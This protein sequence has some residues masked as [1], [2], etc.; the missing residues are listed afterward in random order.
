MLGKKTKTNPTPRL[1]NHAKT[2]SFSL[3]EVIDS[4][5]RISYAISKLLLTAILF[6]SQLKYPSSPFA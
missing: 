5:L 6:I 3:E 1:S 4:E 2:K